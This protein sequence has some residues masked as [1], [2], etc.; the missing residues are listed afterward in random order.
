MFRVDS[1]VIKTAPAKSSQSKGESGLQRA[2][3][4]P[5]DTGGWLCPRSPSPCVAQHALASAKPTA[6]AFGDEGPDVSWCAGGARPASGVPY[7]PS[8]AGFPWRRAPLRTFL[9]LLMNQNVLWVMKTIWLPHARPL[10]E[11]V[12]LGVPSVSLRGA[13]SARFPWWP[14]NPCGRR[15]RRPVHLSARVCRRR[16]SP[17]VAAED[18][19]GLFPETAETIFGFNEMNPF[20]GKLRPFSEE[21]RLSQETH[22]PSLRDGVEVS[23][24]GQRMGSTELAA[25][26]SLL[27][28]PQR[29]PRPQ[30]TPAGPP[31]P[32]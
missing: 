26:A 30:K 5:T 10:G 27:G 22:S 9:V 7:A 24:E 4:P 3:G 8:L 32:G 1:G 19:A 18:K 15:G 20:L 29:C 12:V 11:P 28:S 23:G 31:G 16:Q 17:D 21:T 14:G 13:A 6:L 25:E 2:A